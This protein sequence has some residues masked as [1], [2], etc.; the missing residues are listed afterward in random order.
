MG[1]DIYGGITVVFLLI[2]WNLG[3]EKRINNDN[4]CYQYLCIMVY[5]IGN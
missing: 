4:D 5:F 3:G 1:I 2:W